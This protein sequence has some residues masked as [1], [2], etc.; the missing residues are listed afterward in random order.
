LI[1]DAEWGSE[2]RRLDLVLAPTNP[3]GNLQVEIV[4][5]FTNRALESMSDSLEFTRKGDTDIMPRV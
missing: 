4:L 2:R 5:K 1:L 3:E